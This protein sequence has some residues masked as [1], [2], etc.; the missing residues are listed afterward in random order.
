MTNGLSL[1]KIHHAAFDH[2]IIG[3]RP[4]YVIEVHPKILQ[5]SDGPMLRHGLQGLHHSSLVLPAAQHDRP[6]RDRLRE[7]YDRY[8]RVA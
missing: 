2:L 8:S 4:D 5:E 7:R 6:D 1:C 3:I